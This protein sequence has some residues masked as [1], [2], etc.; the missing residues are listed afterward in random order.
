MIHYTQIRL[1]LLST[2]PLAFLLYTYREDNEALALNTPYRQLHWAHLIFVNAKLLLMPTTLL[3]DYRM[4]AIPL[5]TSLSD[6]RNLLTLLMF[7]TITILVIYSFSKSLLCQDRHRDSNRICDGQLFTGS[8]LNSAQIMAISLSLII[9]PFLPSSNLFFT[10]GFV[11]A[12]RVLYLPSMGLCLLVALGVYRAKSYSRFGSLVIHFGVTL[13]LLS[14]SAKTLQR[15]RDWVS[16][17]T[18]YRSAVKH[19]P[20]N[21]FL[22]SNLAR[23]YSLEENDTATAESLYRYGIDVAPNVYLSYVNYG[24]LLKS[25]G[26]LTEAEI[27]S[28]TDTLIPC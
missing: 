22:I 25:Q 11:V 27:V 8:K 15:N 28:Q 12:E 9:L 16:K 2:H 26:R 18:L 6:P 10:V 13:L 20:T 4:N 5:I 21:G 1:P 14:Y 7:T 3:H 19:F 17:T 24:S 23:E